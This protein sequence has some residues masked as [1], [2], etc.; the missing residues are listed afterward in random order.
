MSEKYLVTGAPGWLCNRLVKVMGQSEMKVRC[1]VLKGMKIE[2]LEECGAEIFY[3]NV[4]NFD[5]LLEATKGIDKVIHAV[6]V[7]HPKKAKDFYD[8]NTG[9]TKNMLEASSQNGVKK[10]LFV[11]SNSAQGYNADK[12]KP[13][14]EEGLERPYTDYGKSKWKAEQIVKE[15]QKSGKLQTVI[16]RPC[17]FYG[18]NPGQIFI[19]LAKYIK[20]GKPPIFGDG[21]NL[22]TMSYIDNTVDGILKAIDSDK[23]NGQIYWLGDEKPYKLIDIYYEMAKNLGVEIKPTYIPWFLCW[24]AE[25]IDQFTGKFGQYHKHLHVMGETGHYIWCDTAKAQQD[26]GYKPGISLQEG[27][28]RTIGSMQEAGIL[29]KI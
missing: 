25:K 11:S 21:Q 27:M 9:G 1:L 13:M 10:F 18:P 3:G 16:V 6:G 8:L 5:S 28:K 20:K 14:T 4:L 2:H 15:Y 24:L 26:F 22:R 23:T 19:E 7:I 29:D 17:W 12:D